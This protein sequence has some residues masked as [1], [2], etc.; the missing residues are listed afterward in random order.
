MDD[1]A[2]DSAL[3]YD[4]PEQIEK[5]STGIYV[6]YNIEHPVITV[7][8]I[9]PQKSGEESLRISARFLLSVQVLGDNQA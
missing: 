4:L 9:D 8:R 1:Q 5:D 7:E 3:C 6:S 2:L